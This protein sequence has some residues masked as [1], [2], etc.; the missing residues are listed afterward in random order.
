MTIINRIP[1]LPPTKT[2]S[3][4]FPAKLLPV[5]PDRN[6]IRKSIGRK[7]L[8][9]Q[10]LC[11]EFV[12]SLK[13]RPHEVIIEGYAGVGGL[14][15]SLLS[16][17][18]SFKE[19]FKWDSNLLDELNLENQSLKEQKS[20]N[21]NKSK[22]ETKKTKYPIWQEDLPSSNSTK[23][24]SESKLELEVEGETETRE[25][26]I[27]KPKVVI[28]SEGSLEL[29][30]R[31]FN[32]PSKKDELSSIGKPISSDPY[33]REIPVIQT[34]LHPNLLLSHST[35]YVWP[36]LPKILENPL[37]VEQLPIH[38]PSLIGVEAT[39][40][41]WEDP[42]PP[43]TIVCQLPDS[44]I[45]EQLAAQWIGSAV[46]DPG[47]K[48]TW[49]WE[50]G[51]IRLALLCG[52]SLYDRIM[53]PPSSI[54]HCKLSVLTQ[55]LFDIVPLPPYHHVVNVDKKSQFIEDRPWKPLSNVPIS[56]NKPIGIPLINLENSLIN[57]FNKENNN[58]KK[59]TITYP[60]DFYPSQTSSQRLIGKQINRPDLLGLMLIPKLNS[61]I[62]SS[63][64]DTWD[65]VMRRLFIRDTLTLEN[66]LPNLNFGAETLIEN[67]ENE[68]NFRGIPVN[69]N[70][71]IRDLTIFEWLRIV[72]VFDKWTFKP[73]NLI[74]D[75]G[76]PDETSRELGQD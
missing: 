45:G 72:D 66:G 46:G 3:K 75:S 26:E 59:R 14:T 32:Y 11:D 2:W 47:Q 20:T 48:R 23:S 65:F 69:R 73:D 64:K 16:G 31:S 67:I 9:N 49:I 39:K 25:E 41:S 60:L 58:N 53:A 17:G 57:S 34:P 12:K 37:V 7:L 44:S 50:W 8:A 33:T 56:K 74:L 36:T 5:S 27:I 1:P 76:S 38:D 24:E 68:N 13:I 19:S 35:A 55:A 15:R 63:Q 29:L 54:I 6:M 10:K 51:R 43:I 52:K 22:S 70:R 30:I 61:P 40:R 62:L 18:E 42:E 28:A 71:V 21:K 4:H